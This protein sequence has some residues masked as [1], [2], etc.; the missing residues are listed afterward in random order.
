M[1]IL[2]I[3]LVLLLFPDSPSSMFIDAVSLYMFNQCQVD[4]QFAW[5]PP[6]TPHCHLIHV[7]IRPCLAFIHIETLGV[8]GWFNTLLAGVIKVC[9]YGPSTNPAL[10]PSDVAL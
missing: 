9:N 3:L 5:G 1:T 2:L 7:C 4:I 8:R 10:P 6:E